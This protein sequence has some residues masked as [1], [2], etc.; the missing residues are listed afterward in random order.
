[1]KKLYR[2]H[3]DYT[4]SCEFL[5]GLFVGEEEM[6][7]SCIG[8]KLYFDLGDIDNENSTITLDWSYIHEIEV[9]DST[10]NNLEEV[11][12]EY[13]CGHNPLDYIID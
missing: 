8:K 3:Y 2:F 12:G 7:E 10:I 9:L 13:I 5:S 1:M 11:C 6:T 4:D